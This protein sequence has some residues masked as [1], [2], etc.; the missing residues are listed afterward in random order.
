MIKYICRKHR[1]EILE[2]FKYLSFSSL[3]FFFFILVQIF[4]VFVRDHLCLSK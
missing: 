4:V 3:N 1:F 2:Y